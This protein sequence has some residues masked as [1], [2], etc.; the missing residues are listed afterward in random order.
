M[1]KAAQGRNERVG[2]EGSSLRE[3]RLA[4]LPWKQDAL[5]PHIGARTVAFHYGEHHRGYLDKLRDALEDK[6]EA[7][8]D[9][10]ELVRRAEGH[11]Y[12]LAAQVWNHDFYWR[13]L[14]PAG[15]GRPG[16]ELRARVER[17]FGSFDEAKR[18]LAE[19]AN[20]HFGSGWAWLA[21]GRDQRLRALATHDAGNPLRGGMTPLLALDVWEHAYYLDYQH[22]RDR[23]VESVVDHLL[24][25]EFAAANLERAA[26]RRR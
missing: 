23:Y 16:G 15:G 21:C 22:E 17:D 19:V 8:L 1:A 7:Q 20:G 25:W 3:W 14:K 26:S 10:E 6:P 24:D 4:P 13:S 18:R 2:F 11:V 9:L 5:E 12:D